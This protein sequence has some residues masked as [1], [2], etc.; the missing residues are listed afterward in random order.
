MARTE[1]ET[2]FG[3]A[4]PTRGTARRGRLEARRDRASRPHCAV[5][6]GRPGEGERVA[7]PLFG[8]IGRAAPRRGLPLETLDL[9]PTGTI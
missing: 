7:N 8:A 4:L 6:G 1:D 2:P 5:A 9:R 3:E